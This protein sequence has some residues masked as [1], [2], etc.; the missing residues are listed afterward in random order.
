M[1]KKPVA[2]IDRTDIQRLVDESVQE[3]G[4]IEFKR[5]LP[6]RRDGTPDAWMTGGGEIGDRAKQ[7]VVEEVIAF[8]NTHGGTLLVGIEETRDR[9]PRAS[10]IAPVP[11]CAEAAERFRMV[12]RDT[13]DPRLP[14]LEVVG[15]PTQ[16]DGAGVIVFQVPQSRM[17]PH[18]H[19]QTLHC[20]RRHGESS[21]KMNMREIQDLTLQVERGIALIEERFR[22]RADAFF[23]RLQSDSTT[24]A[25]WYALRSTL[26]PLSPINAR[27]LRRDDPLLPR[28]QKFQATVEGTP[29]ELFVPRSLVPWR[30]G[31]RAM[32]ASNG[33][34]RYSVRCEVTS[35]G[36]IEFVVSRGQAD[37]GDSAFYPEWFMGLV[38]NSLIAAERFRVGVGSPDVEYGL[39]LEI[40]VQ[41]SAVPITNY[42]PDRGP[43]SHC[44]ELPAQR[45]IFPR[46]SVGP[47]EEFTELASEIEIDLWNLAGEYVEVGIVIDFDEALR[48]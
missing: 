11:R 46:Y 8:A 29:T 48:S 1:F 37:P 19:T 35:D 15:V 26:I 12:C 22:Q 44:G 4:D 25:C 17:A 47:S 6:G 41:P 10:T 31:M 32:T 24:K 23:A 33:D 2:E 18:R 14:T 42:G 45:N 39:E 36:L 3:G 27:R 20:Y 40:R 43:A 38:A 28:F 21:E 16:D 13:I 7:E 5:E 9:P 34:E 30:P